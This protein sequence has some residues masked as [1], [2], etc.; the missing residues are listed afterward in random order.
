MLAEGQCLFIF[1]RTQCLRYQFFDAVLVGAQLEPV[2]GELRRQ[3]GTD[4]LI[5]LCHVRFPERNVGAVHVGKELQGV[6]RY[7]DRV[8]GDAPYGYLFSC[9]GIQKLPYLPE[10]LCRKLLRAALQGDKGG[11]KHAE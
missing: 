5:N 4:A 2:F 11:G 10:G 9:G 7:G 8:D 1:L 3:Q 6:A